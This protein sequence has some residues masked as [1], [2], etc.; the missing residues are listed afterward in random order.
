MVIV[1]ESSPVRLTGRQLDCSC[2]ATLKVSLGSCIVLSMMLIRNKPDIS[3]LIILTEDVSCED[4]S[5]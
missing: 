1:K 4:N 5:F 3:P 2:N